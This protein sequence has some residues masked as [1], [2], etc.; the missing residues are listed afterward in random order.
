MSDKKDRAKTMRDK[1][2][3]DYFQKIGAMGGKI[4]T[5]KGFGVNKELARLAGAK[6]GRVSRRGKVEKEERSEFKEES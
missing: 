6:G 3:E 2:G 1:Y 5:P 4:K